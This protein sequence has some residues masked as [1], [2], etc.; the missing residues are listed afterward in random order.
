MVNAPE[1]RASFALFWICLGEPH[2]PQYLYH[3]YGTSTLTPP[4]LDKNEHQKFIATIL[5]EECISVNRNRLYKL[6]SIYH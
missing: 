6:C 3:K 5:Q 4:P 2:L 1:P